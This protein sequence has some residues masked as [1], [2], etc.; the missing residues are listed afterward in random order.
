[1]RLSLRQ[2]L[3]GVL[4]LVRDGLGN[5]TAARPRDCAFTSGG[6]YIPAWLYGA[7]A[8]APGV[9]IFHTAWGLSAHERA[10]ARRL[11]E[12]GFACMV[13][14]YT[15]LTTGP[16]VLADIARRESLEKV[17]SDALQHLRA[18]PEVNASR[19]GVIGFSLGGYFAVH[20]AAGRTPPE[21]AVV[22]YGVYPTAEPLMLTLSVPL[23][24]LQ[25]ERD[26]PAFVQAADSAAQAAAAQGRSCEL[27][28][29]PEA[30]HQF[31]LFQPYG[32]PASDAWERTCTF[33]GRH[34][35]G[36]SAG[37]QRPA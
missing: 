33:I 17:A 24:I 22:Y 9:L 28:T 25:G 37:T 12:A 21:A 35:R 31:D 6:R 29:Y 10:F 7:S 32:Q 20:L 13:L 2:R 14:S 27:I 19:V 8:Q 3:A 34:L 30:V 11:A 1:M 16:A 4:R 26:D 18:Q 15:P 23:L 36:K 5:A